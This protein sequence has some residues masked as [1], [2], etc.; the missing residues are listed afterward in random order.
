LAADRGVGSQERLLD[1]AEHESRDIGALIV[2]LAP[3]RL[4]LGHEH[5]SDVVSEGIAKL[6]DVPEHE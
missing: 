4:L 3:G 1:D 2:R 5:F 6:G